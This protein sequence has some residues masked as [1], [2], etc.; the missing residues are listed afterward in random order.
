MVVSS[1]R[2]GHGGIIRGLHTRM[3]RVSSSSFDLLVRA[4]VG[5]ALH[6]DG[7]PVTLFFGVSI[8]IIIIHERGRSQ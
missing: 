5:W 7:L 3:E 8:N 2:Q 4:E 1:E 6:W